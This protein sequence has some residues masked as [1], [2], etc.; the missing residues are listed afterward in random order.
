MRCADVT[1]SVAGEELPTNSLHE[2]LEKVVVQDNVAANA[3]LRMLSSAE[4]D[5]R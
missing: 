2:M 3:R 5:L 1:L 4:P